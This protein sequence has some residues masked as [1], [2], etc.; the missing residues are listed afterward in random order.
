M[1]LKRIIL[2]GSIEHNWTNHLINLYSLRESFEIEGSSNFNKLEYDPEKFKN[3]CNRGL[4]YIFCFESLMPNPITLVED[5][6]ILRSMFPAQVLK[7]R[8]V[9][10]FVQKTD[11]KKGLNE[12]R[13]KFVSSL[14]Y[15]F[16]LLD[17]NCLNERNTFAE[18]NIWQLDSYIE[19]D[20]FLKRIACD[21][22]EIY[23]PQFFAF[24][25]LAIKATNPETNNN[26]N[27]YYIDK[28][29]TSKNTLRNLTNEQDLVRFN[30]PSELISSNND[31][32]EIRNDLNYEPNETSLRFFLKDSY[33]KLHKELIIKQL[34]KVSNGVVYG[35]ILE[36]DECTC[37]H[38]VLKKSSDRSFLCTCNRL[39]LNIEYSNRASEQPILSK[40]TGKTY[41]AQI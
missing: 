19:L 9:I 18:N 5:L 21:F 38:P 32:D 10:L 41:L 33:S 34:E 14:N 13:R 27:P 8:L 30:R 16:K 22:K 25:Q 12:T 6:K 2:A 39:D 35:E 26:L 15:V 1:A 17:I 23:Y 3:V 11:F 24:P 31:F 20:R 28:P 40:I 4:H 7:E 37:D 29:N 36:C